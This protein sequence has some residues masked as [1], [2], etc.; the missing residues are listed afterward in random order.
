MGAHRSQAIATPLTDPEGR[1]GELRQ[2]YHAVQMNQTFLCRRGIRNP[3]LSMTNST[4]RDCGTELARKLSLSNL[5]NFISNIVRR[6]DVVHEGIV[7]AAKLE[8]SEVGDPTRL[9]ATLF[10]TDSKNG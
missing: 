6:S 7:S 3:M 8:F 10:A 2:I 5:S 4:R 9:C 1:A